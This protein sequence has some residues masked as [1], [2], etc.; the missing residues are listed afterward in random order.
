[1]RGDFMFKIF[2]F[3]TIAI[4]SACICFL[5]I[6][7]AFFNA[8]SP[9]IAASVSPTATVP[10]VMYHQIKDT[11][12]NWGNYILPTHVLKEDFEYLKKTGITPVSFD[13][14]KDFVENGKPLPKKAIVLTF[15]DG[16]KS[17]LTKVVPLLEEY[18]YPAN[19]NIVGSLI[20]LYTKNGETDDRYAYL[21]EEDIISLSKNP[22]IEIGCHSYNLHSLSNRRGMGK[23]YGE[24]DEAY[25]AFIKTDFQNFD[26]V[27]TSHLNKSL[28]ILAYPYGI[29]NDILL[30]FAKEK[31][32]TITLTCRESVNT[33]TVGGDL[34]E[35]GRFN[36][37]YGKSSKDFF[38]RFYE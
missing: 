33:L 37:P 6:S 16:E 9:I 1:M 5:L 13:D 24:A 32:Y 3:K 30:G 19:V 18:S 14:L 17:F 7:G 15:D 31:G 28:R 36:R 35:L 26:S 38:S 20:E 34:Y 12:S 11:S 27:V 23:L 8:F 25:L 21:N 10:I 2:T 29:R 22:L 4:L